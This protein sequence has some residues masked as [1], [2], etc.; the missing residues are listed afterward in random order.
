MNTVSVLFVCMGNICRSPTA[1]GVF[2]HKVGLRGWS[3]AVAVDSAGTHNY[4]PDSPPD[5]RSQA[6]AA[7]RGYDLS[8]LRARQIQA[9]DFEAFDLIL[10]MD[11]DNLALVREQCPEPH[12][13]K[14][15]RLTE[16]CLQFDS[17]VVPD[18]YY[19]GAKDFEQVL[20][21]VED[22]CD[23]L[24]QQLSRQEQLQ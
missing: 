4:H 15:R 8:D 6:H 22:A 23:G 10:V 3:D 2:R 14:V 18:P 1:H 7:K 12:L 16:F 19:G 20:D 24:L 5:E 21:L 11:Q 9:A 17:P 13:H